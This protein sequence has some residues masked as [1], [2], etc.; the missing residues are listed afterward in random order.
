MAV[1]L[2]NLYFKGAIKFHSLPGNTYCTFD[3]TQNQMAWQYR[4]KIFKCLFSFIRISLKYIPKVDSLQV[5]VGLG[6]GLIS[7]V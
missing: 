4:N 2:Q 3:W 5:N 6:N 7:L 1:L